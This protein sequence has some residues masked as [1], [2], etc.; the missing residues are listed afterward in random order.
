[1]PVAAVKAG[2]QSQL[3]NPNAPPAPVQHQPTRAAQN[4]PDVQNDA[5]PFILTPDSPR[6]DL[7]SYGS[8][9]ALKPHQ[10][11]VLQRLLDVERNCHNSH[12]LGILK[13]KAGSGKTFCILALMMLEKVSNLDLKRTNIIVVPLTIH[14]QWREAIDMFNTG[15]DHPLSYTDFTE[16]ASV[17]SLMHGTLNRYSD[18][19][20]TTPLYA[21]TI[22]GACEAARIAVDRLVF[23]EADS[24]EWCIHKEAHAGFIWFVSA[25][26]R[27]VPGVYMPRVQQLNKLQIESCSV[28]CQPSFVDTVWKLPV[29]KTHRVKCSSTYVDIVMRPLLNAEQLDRVNAGDYHELPYN[30]MSKVPQNDKEAVEMMIESCKAQI[31]M[32]NPIIDVLQQKVKN[33][34]NNPEKV[35]TVSQLNE[36]KE[37]V[38]KQEKALDILTKGMESVKTH[39]LGNKLKSVL[40]VLKQTPTGSQA[41]VYCKH[42]Q[43][44]D[45]LGTILRD[46]GIKYCQLDAGTIEEIDKLIARYKTGDIQ[47]F[48]GHAALFG[49]GLN[50]E[51]TTDIVFLHRMDNMTDHQ[52]VG[53]A[54]RPGRKDSLRIWY[55]LYDNE[56]A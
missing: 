30:T 9:L 46:A 6:A 44:F 18:I 28:W 26:F 14:T 52:V 12:K 48:L 2:E 8:P 21:D 19:L 11:A 54:N 29:A 51:N 32:N 16:Y 3:P 17:A 55:M 1:M 15:A 20:I 35:A 13:D 50:L 4:I 7:D 41:I 10:L 31:S 23:D 5:S 53:R 49:Q 33:M 22:I 38:K 37:E 27:Q 47:V 25:S 40:S 36:T 34:G 56:L 39:T 43:I 42:I 45:K 24:I